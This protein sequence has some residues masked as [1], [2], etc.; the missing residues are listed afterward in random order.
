[1][2]LKLGSNIQ[3]KLDNDEDGKQTIL[4]VE[5]IENLKLEEFSLAE[6]DTGRVSIETWIKSKN[7]YHNYFHLSKF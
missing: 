5:N 3:A 2:E 4:M 6:P 1:M 7:E